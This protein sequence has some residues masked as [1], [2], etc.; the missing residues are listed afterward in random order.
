VNDLAAELTAAGL[1]VDVHVEGERDHIPAA[2]D[3]TAF[4]LVQESLT[5]V[6]KHAGPAR[7]EVT[8]RYEPGALVLEVVDDGQGPPAT[9]ER[10]TPGHGQIGM[11][12]RVSV[13]GGSLAAGPR[14]GGGYRVAARFPHTE[15]ASR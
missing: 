8:I 11:R 6:V 2:L 14:P 3:L 4:R 1:P 5:N 15:L 9:T 10:P 12:E 7:A 13:W